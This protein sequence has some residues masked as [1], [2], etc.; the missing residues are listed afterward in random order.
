M[1]PGKKRKNARNGNPNR[2]P[3]T[4]TAIDATDIATRMMRSF[5]PSVCPFPPIDADD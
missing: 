1:I 3:S 4:V 5:L 2:S